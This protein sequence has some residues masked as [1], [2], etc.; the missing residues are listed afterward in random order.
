MNA[1]FDLIETEMKIKVI[2]AAHPRSDYTEHKDVYGNRDIIYNKTCQLVKDSEFVI[3]HF[4][5]SLSY[6]SL[7]KKPMLIVV[8]DD[9]IHHF[10][11]AIMEICKQMR[12]DYLR[13]DDCY[14]IKSVIS[15]IKMD[16]EVYT[17][18]IKRYMKKD[19]NGNLEGEPLWVQIGDFLKKLDGKI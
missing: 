16:E 14:N 3:Y 5:N 13:I 7:Y 15:K 10:S 12:M 8:N 4:S 18:Y 6:V 19:Y 17:N 1:L 11:N 2:I 9:I